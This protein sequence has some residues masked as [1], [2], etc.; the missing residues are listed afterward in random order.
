M[1]GPRRVKSGNSLMCSCLEGRGGTTSGASSHHVA[2]AVD[3][4]GFCRQLRQRNLVPCQFRLRGQVCFL[5]E[6]RIELVTA[7]C[8][9]L[10]GGMTA[11]F[12]VVDFQAIAIS[13]QRGGVM[14]RGS[15]GGESNLA[16]G[17]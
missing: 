4:V 14:Q 8:T 1:R 12:N 9:P 15:M 5:V 6:V 2:C 13:I 7:S 10:M 16:T 3:V 11:G 17:K